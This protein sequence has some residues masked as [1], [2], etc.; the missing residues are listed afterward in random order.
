M[1][2]F[3]PSTT[4][5]ALSLL[6]KYG[7]KAMPVAGGTFF[8]SHR[9]QLFTEVEALVSVMKLGL[10]YIKEDG[11]G[12]KIGPTTRLASLLESDILSHG[13]FMVVREAINEIE[14]PEIRNMA[15]LGG[16][17]SISAEVDM[18]VPLLVI[19]TKLLIEALDSKRTLSLD[20]FYVGYLNTRLEPG[21]IITEIQVPRFHGKT[22]AA[23]YK[24][25][26]VAVD[27]PVVNAAA[28]I[29]LDDHDKCK[30][31]KIVLGG[32][33]DIPVRADKAEKVLIGSSLDEDSITKAAEMAAKIECVTDI[34]AS[35]ELRQRWAKIAVERVLSKAHERAQGEG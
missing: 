33:A 7:E 20:E 2:Y 30:T 21:E 29:T 17:I 8:M 16:D 31:A 24:L 6:N 5:E 10:S 23:F 12:L 15:T 22:G 27:V 28:R 4:Q 13:A 35:S 9:H 11:D 14:I 1:E 34:R 19:D 25:K 26:R 18:P 32:V 3:S